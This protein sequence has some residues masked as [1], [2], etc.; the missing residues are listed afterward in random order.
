MSNRKPALKAAASRAIPA[1]PA[2]RKS[3][4]PDIASPDATTLDAASPAPCA[5][6]NAR[7]GSASPEPRSRQ[8]A[9]AARGEGG[10]SE[11]K[12]APAVRPI[13]TSDAR[14]RRNA[15]PPAEKIKAVRSAAL[16]EPTPSNAPSVRRKPTGDAPST[17]DK[18]PAKP[19]AGSAVSTSSASSPPSASPRAGS[20][21]ALVLALLARAE[22]AS[23]A[24]LVAATGWLA[25]TTRAALTGLRKKGFCLERRH[26]DD[27]A[28]RYHLR[29]ADAAA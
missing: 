26:D 3:A 5:R 10:R 13:S 28:S 29:G 27:G 6:R 1:K 24:E 15:P 14:A 2:P 9:P 7:D 8:A 19:D 17:T 12:A 20:K 4:T 25:H 22:G 21:Q 16:K 23:L 18:R 11:A